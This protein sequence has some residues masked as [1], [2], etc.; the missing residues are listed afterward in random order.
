MARIG[1]LSLASLAFVVGYGWI[2]GP[3]AAPAGVGSGEPHK[4]PF[5]ADLRAEQ[6][7]LA[8]LDRQIEAKVKELA[9]LRKKAD[10]LRA[11]VR[12]GQTWAEIISKTYGAKPDERGPLSGGSGYT[13]IV[14][15]GNY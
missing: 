7:E 11:R 10:P 1:W 6:K 15:E 3:P 9:E 5:P 4:R 14:T 8:E 12:L 2:S 13:G